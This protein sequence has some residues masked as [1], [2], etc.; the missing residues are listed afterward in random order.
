MVGSAKEHK[1]PGGLRSGSGRLGLYLKR[2]QAGKTH[3]IAAKLMHEYAED[4]ST[5]SNL[6]LHGEVAHSKMCS[7]NPLA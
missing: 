5:W 6:H 7:D 4:E 1:P 2:S 3:G